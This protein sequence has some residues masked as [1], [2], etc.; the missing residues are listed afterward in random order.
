MEYA[1]KL[2][3]KIGKKTFDTGKTSEDWDNLAKDQKRLNWLLY[4]GWDLRLLKGE[5]ATLGGLRDLIDRE[6]KK[7]ELKLKEEIIKA[8][9]YYKI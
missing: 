2:Y 8:I 5:Q 7:E 3:G 4:S 1:G 9:P 6:I